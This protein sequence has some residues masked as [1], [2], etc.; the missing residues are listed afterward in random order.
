LPAGSDWQNAFFSLNSADLT[1]GLG[2]VELALRNATELRIF[3]N[4]L[5]EFPFPPVGPPAV[6]ADLGI[7]Q[8]AAVTVPEPSPFFLGG[9]GLFLI[10]ACRRRNPRL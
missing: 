5:P 10:L 1:A 2:A 4:N 7:D 9:L 6:T 3:H 8:I